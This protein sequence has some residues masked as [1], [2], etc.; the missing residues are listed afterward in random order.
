VPHDNTGFAR[1]CTRPDTLRLTT[2]IEGP[3]RRVFSDDNGFGV[4]ASQRF[5][6]SRIGREP[7]VAILRRATEGTAQYAR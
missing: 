5:A 4:P 3:A 1:D 2:V 7:D 6:S